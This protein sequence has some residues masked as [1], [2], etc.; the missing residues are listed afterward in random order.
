VFVPHVL[1]HLSSNSSKQGSKDVMK[2]DRLKIGLI[3]IKIEPFGCTLN[4]LHLNYCSLQIENHICKEAD[5][6]INNLRSTCIFL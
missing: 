1:K 5:N 4:W 2:Y 3:K 6:G